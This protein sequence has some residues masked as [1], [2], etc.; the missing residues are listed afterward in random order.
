MGMTSPVCVA[1]ACK[2]C[3]PHGS[4]RPNSLKFFVLRTGLGVFTG[5]N[6][7]NVNAVMRM[8]EQRTVGERVCVTMFAAKARGSDTVRAMAESS[9]VVGG[10]EDEGRK[11]GGRCY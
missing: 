11:M 5:Q 6:L 1:A 8:H 4:T 9:G 7:Q 10:G 3:K 2:P